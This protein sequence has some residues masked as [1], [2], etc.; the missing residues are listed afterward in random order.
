MPRS[1]DT[2]LCVEKWSADLQIKQENDFQRS[3]VL[4]KQE[5]LQGQPAMEAFDT[6]TGPVVDAAI[7]LD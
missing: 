1:L 5:P 2:H 4:A 3:V 6:K 7:R